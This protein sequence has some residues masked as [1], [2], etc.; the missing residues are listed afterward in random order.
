MYQG[1]APFQVKAFP[2]P[3]HD[4]YTGG[5]LAGILFNFLLVFAFQ[6]PTRNM[7]TILVREKELQL[8]GYMRVLGLQDAAYWGSWLAT[9]LCM[10]W[11]TGLLCAGIGMC[12]PCSLWP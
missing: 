6:Q 9:H 1:A 11:L 8:R 12:A 3:A 4:L 10:L 7:V 5:I 2:W